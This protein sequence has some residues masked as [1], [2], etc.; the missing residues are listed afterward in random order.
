MAG[1]SSK[2]PINFLDSG[3]SS[4]V[5]YDKYTSGHA[6]RI[7]DTPTTSKRAVSC[8]S[9]GGKLR[10]KLRSNITFAVLISNLNGYDYVYV[11]LRIFHRPHFCNNRDK[12]VEP[13]CLECS[14]IKLAP[15]G[16][17]VDAVST[18]S[19]GNYDAYEL[20]ERF[21][22]RK[23]NEKVS[24]SKKQRKHARVQV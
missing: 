10:W 22:K 15:V 5:T 8:C 16:S 24:P 2:N 14:R 9:C 4:N 21:L 1:S 20:M 12:S 11:I 6:L 17:S 3:A 19:L 13:Y 23:K 18:Y 7:W